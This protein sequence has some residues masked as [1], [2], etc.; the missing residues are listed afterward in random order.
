MV[1]KT[2]AIVKLR[3]EI[4][5]MRGHDKVPQADQSRICAGGASGAGC[6]DVDGPPSRNSAPVRKDWDASRKPAAEHKKSGRG[7]EH[8]GSANKPVPRLRYA[9]IPENARAA[10]AKT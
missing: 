2:A 9:T 7:R 5:Q 6:E 8:P 10:A 3:A 1:E 4:G